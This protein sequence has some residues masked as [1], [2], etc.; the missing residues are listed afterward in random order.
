MHGIFRR[1]ADGVVLR[2]QSGVELTPS[3]EL[4]SEERRSRALGAASAKRRE[5][6]GKHG[7]QP[8]ERE[9]GREG[10]RGKESGPEE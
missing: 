2:N 7:A 5:R 8:G 1:L 4:L 3:N 9:G 6:R 10:G